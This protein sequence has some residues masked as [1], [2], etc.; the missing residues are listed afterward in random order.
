[1]AGFERE[2][3]RL[4]EETQAAH[5][6]IQRCKAEQDQSRERTTNLKVHTIRI[7]PKR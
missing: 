3:V 6:H 4:K 7:V 2:M 5:Q 1:V